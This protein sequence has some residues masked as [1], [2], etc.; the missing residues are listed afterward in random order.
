MPDITRNFIRRWPALL[1]GAT[2][3][4]SALAQSDINSNANSNT[5]NTP[6]NTSNTSNTNNRA[7][8]D[9][10]NTGA[11][12]DAINNSSPNNNSGTANNSTTTNNASTDSRSTSA[13]TNGPVL[14][15]PP[16]QAR[17]QRREIARGDPPR[18]YRNDSTEADQ[19][20]ALRKEIAAALQES[21]QA[22]R[23]M[24]ANERSSCIKDARATYRHDMT[25][26]KAILQDNKRLE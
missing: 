16:A 12:S 4:A 13:D 14:A 17:E 2:L 7:T 6:S 18:W 26:A 21:T 5:P 20:R 10:N 22:C 24:P 9:T 19:M 11:G 1:L 8:N 15:T 23:Q 3:C 25:H